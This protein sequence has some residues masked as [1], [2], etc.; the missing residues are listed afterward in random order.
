MIDIEKDRLE[1]SID[2]SKLLHYVKVEFDR[3]IQCGKCV[4]MCPAAGV[5]SFNSRRIIQMIKSDEIEEVLDSDYIWSC[6]LCSACYAL[7][8]NGINFTNALMVLR[9]LSFYYGKGWEMERIAVPFIENYLKTGMA[10]SEAEEPAV[11]DVLKTRTGTDGTIQE[12]RSRIGL[13]PKRNVSQKAMDEISKLAGS[14]GLLDK[15][16]IIKNSH[17]SKRLIDEDNIKALCNE[18]FLLIGKLP[19]GKQNES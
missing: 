5:S 2:L 10:V 15:L 8:P 14:S 13:E 12:I 4:G 18:I 9:V 17:Q 19:G 16:N 7:C 11:T 3:C 1:E 6:V